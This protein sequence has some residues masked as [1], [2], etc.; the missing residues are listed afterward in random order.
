MS[1]THSAVWNNCL[2]FIKDN[3]QP[4]AF[5]TWFE[6]IIPVKLSEDVLSIQVP[7]KF[8]YEW[9]EEHYVKI[10]RIALTKE[11]GSEARLVYI[12]KMENIISAHPHI[13]LNYN[14]TTVEEIT[15]ALE[16]SLAFIGRPWSQHDKLKQTE[17][18][19]N[20][21]QLQTKQLCKCLDKIDV[22]YAD[23]IRSWDSGLDGTKGFDNKNVFD[24]AVKTLTILRKTLLKKQSTL[25]R[26]SKLQQSFACI[27]AIKRI[28]SIRKIL[29]D[30]N[31][32]DN[33]IFPKQTDVSKLI[34]QFWC[35]YQSSEY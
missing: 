17:Q 7:S 27:D 15:S 28:T 32:Q 21:L 18:R 16:R 35:L 31:E 30:Q 20:E 25:P 29:Q 26:L 11:L 3:I 33:F 14:M 1:Q 9:L 34:I 12:I 19:Y 24:S 23:I 8:F 10:L 6:P 13:I 4:Q 2:S 5:K 22:S